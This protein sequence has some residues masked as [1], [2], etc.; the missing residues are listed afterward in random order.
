MQNHNSN[1]TVGGE[2]LYKS[3]TLKF[4]YY[5]MG[6]VSVCP[7][8]LTENGFM[9]NRYD[10]DN[11]INDDINTQKAKAITKGIVEYFMSIKE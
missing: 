8:V 11:I 6:R 2:K 9:S 1:L 3:T 7:V 4:H 10:F 5:F